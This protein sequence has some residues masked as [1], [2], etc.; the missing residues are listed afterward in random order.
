[1]TRLSELRNTA[2]QRRTEFFRTTQVLAEKTRPLRLVDEAVGAADPAFT[3]LKRAS[4][5]MQEYPVV[6]LVALTLVWVLTSTGQAGRERQ[7]PAPRH[8][9]RSSR[10]LSTTNKGEDHGYFNTSSR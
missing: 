8:H 5:R 4:A 2:D 3:V 9:R 6:V 1:M 7:N 10:L